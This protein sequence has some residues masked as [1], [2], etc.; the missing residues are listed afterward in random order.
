MTVPVFTVGDRVRINE[1]YLMSEGGVLHQADVS[2]YGRLVRQTGTVVHIGPYVTV[3][4]DRPDS[5]YMD[6]L[7]RRIE[8]DLLDNELQA[9]E[10]AALK[11]VIAEL[12]AFS[13]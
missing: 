1:Y 2:S 5:R 12:S 11:S 7:C 13:P 6:P 3:R 8:L 4:L 9:E 10:R